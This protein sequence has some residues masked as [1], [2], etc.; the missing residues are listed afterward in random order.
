[1]SYNF[2]DLF[3]GAGG[4][5]YGFELE[6]LN[7]VGGIE[8]DP[9]TV[10]THKLNHPNS[11]TINADIRDIEPEEFDEEIGK[12]DVDIIIGGPPCPTFS[13]IGHAKIREVN[14]GPV[15]DDP[16]NNLFVE[17][18]RFVEYFKPEIFIIENVPTF[19]SKYKGKVYKTALEMIKK[20]DDGAYQVVTPVRVLNSVYYGVPQK[21]KRMFLVCYRKDAEFP[22]EYPDHTHY[23]N[24]KGESNTNL[25]LFDNK[26]NEDDNKK[27]K[28]Y[29]TVG[30]AIGDLP[31]ITDDWRINEVEYSKFDNLTEY[32]KLMRKNNPNKTVK[33]NICRMSNENAKKVFSHMDQGDIY[34]DVPKEIRDLLPFREDI[35]QDRLRRLMWDEPSW[36]ILA[37]IGMDGYRYIHPTELRTLSVR[38]AAR[39]QSFPD[40]FEFIGNQQDTYVQVGNAVPVLLSKALAKSVKE[41]FQKNNKG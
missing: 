41:F 34:M 6:G 30:D 36:T 5:S 15:Y 13:N 37:H 20:L 29:N 4:F 17:F 12:K 27:L 24:Q 1:M 22:F 35:F 40:E 9:R 32:Q 39:I 31:D 16:R 10:K 8:K 38:E 21:R 18:L 33:N 2:I 25:N 14:G 3:S 7:C 26:N 19:M 28:E 23:Y 11:V